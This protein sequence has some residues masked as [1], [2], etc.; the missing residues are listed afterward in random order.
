MST[1]PYWRPEILDFNDLPKDIKYPMARR[2]MDHDGSLSGEIMLNHEDI[3]FLEGLR[4][5]GNK[6]VRSGAIDLI[7]AIEKYDRIVFKIT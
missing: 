6:E 5:A 4:E 1:N 2:Y 3:G 7:E